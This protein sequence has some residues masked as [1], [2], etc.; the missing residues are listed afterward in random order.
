MNPRSVRRRREQVLT[1]MLLVAGCDQQQY[2]GDPRA[3][4][5]SGTPTDLGPVAVKRLFVT[6]SLYR[7]T[8]LGGLAG[9]DLRC[10]QVADSATR[11]GLA[12]L[13]GARWV[14]WLSDGST[15]AIERLADLGPWYLVDKQ[16]RIFNNRAHVA[17]APAMLRTGITQDERGNPIAITS[18]NSLYWTGTAPGGRK[19]PGHCDSWR[20]PMY[21][22]G[23]LTGAIGEVGDRWTARL[24]SACIGA[25]ALLCFEQ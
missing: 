2:L 23:G 4:A 21:S 1:A 17:L 18:A 5:D 20:D 6:S 3:A 14:A 10:Q 13:G 25:H 12:D 11:A 8:E 19:A 22:E 24:S 9:A 7:S 16:T 15:D